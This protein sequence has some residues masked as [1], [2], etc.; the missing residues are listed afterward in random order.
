VDNYLA[1]SDKVLPLLYDELPKV[2]A[3]M[4]K[5]RQN[6]VRW[7]EHLEPWAFRNE[8]DRKRD[9]FLERYSTQ[10]WR[11]WT[12]ADQRTHEALRS[13][14]LASALTREE[15]L[16]RAMEEAAATAAAAAEAQVIERM[17]DEEASVAEVDVATH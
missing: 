10:D 14:G 2:E 13:R 1:M 9:R 12:L 3:Q 8:L 11:S 17:V 4:A 16:R 15:R 6:R 5:H 7:V